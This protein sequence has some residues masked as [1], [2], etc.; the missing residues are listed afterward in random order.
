MSLRGSG[1]ASSSS[2]QVSCVVIC[3][4]P[5]DWRRF[6]SVAVDDVSA[7]PHQH[8]LAG[9]LRRLILRVM[10]SRRGVMYST[11]T[12]NLSYVSVMT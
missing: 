8:L 2:S 11:V 10:S 9:F 4:E 7:V 12:H 1:A 6:W 5:V 3:R